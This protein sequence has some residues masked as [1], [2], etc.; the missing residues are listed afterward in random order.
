MN[1]P[2]PAVSTAGNRISVIGRI[3]EFKVSFPVSGNVLGS[4]VTKYLVNS[5]K[6]NICRIVAKFKA[7]E[8][9]LDN[10]LLKEYFQKKDFF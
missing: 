9:S 1:K 5:F 3:S 7:L 4:N 8:V 10:I 2:G 6:N